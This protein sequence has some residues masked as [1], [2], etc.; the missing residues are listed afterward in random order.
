MALVLDGSGFVRKSKVFAGNVREHRTLEEMLE[1]LQAG[2]GALVVMD[3]GI[4]TEDRIQ[5][6]QAQKY[7]YIVVARERRRVFDPEAAQTLTTAGGE[8]LSL[9]RQV[10]D[11]PG[12]ALLLL[13][14]P[15]CEGASHSGTADRRV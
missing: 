10:Q 11:D 14:V 7:Q 13:C 4:A 15:G 1:V 2:P 6:L 3:R 8:R 9:Y 5:W 12:A